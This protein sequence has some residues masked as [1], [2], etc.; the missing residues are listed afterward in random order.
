MSTTEAARAEAFASQADRSRALAEGYVRQALA[1]AKAISQIKGAID[2]ALNNITIDHRWSGT[3]LELLSPNGQWIQGPDLGGLRGIG[4]SAAT[5]DEDFHLWLTFE[6]GEEVDAGALPA[7][8]AGLAGSIEIAAVETLPAGSPAEVINSGTPHQ[9]VLTFK[10]PQGN[11]GQGSGDMLAATY[12]P[13]GKTADA[14]S[15]DNHSDGATNKVFTA[16][17]RAKLAGVAA[18]ATANDSDANLRN[19]ANHTGTQAQSTIANLASDLA[20]KAP[21]ANPTFTGSVT[22]PGDPTANL[23]AATKQ[24][25]DGLLAN[26]GKRGRVRVATT[27]NITISTALNNGDVIDGVTLATGDLVLVKNQT[28]GSQNGVYVVGAS[29]ARSADYD[30]WDEFPGSLIGVAEGTANGDTLWLCTNNAGGTLGTTAVAFSQLRVFG[31]LLAANNLGDVSDPAASFGNIKQA[32]TE[33]SSG[34]MEIGTADE[35][36]GAAAGVA[37]TADKAWEAAVPVAVSLTG[38]VTVDMATFINRVITATG[39]I[40]LGQTLNV[41]KGQSFVW[42]F[43]H[44]GAARTIALNSTYWSTPDGAG[45]TLSAASG[46]RDILTGYVMDNGK[47]MISV[48]ARGVA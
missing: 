23:H 33:T 12:D 19:R 38:S 16:A 2:A 42:E 43:I 41:K 36:R 15:A 13:Q 25:V 34:V 5:I 29:P 46:A 21:L 8:P 47:V 17:E 32:A 3:R 6:D 18:G 35:F 14:F 9:A 4:L 40:T 22:L 24:Y 20:A 39:N 37:L 26:V 7:G 48:L 30:S 31:E 27:A 44:S 10:L 11:D 1:I 28:T 45:L